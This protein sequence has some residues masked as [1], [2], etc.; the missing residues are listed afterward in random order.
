M[1]SVACMHACCAPNTITPT[2]P[3]SLP[4]SLPF[5]LHNN[6]QSPSRAARQG[7]GTGWTGSPF[8]AGTV[9]AIIVMMTA[10]ARRNAHPSIRYVLACSLRQFVIDAR[11]FSSVLAAV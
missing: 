3:G 10:R 7:P 9:S 4:R 1:S 11:S 2:V 5:L 8:M 6:Y